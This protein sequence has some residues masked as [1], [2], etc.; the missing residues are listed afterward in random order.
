[1]KTLT[2]ILLFA[3]SICMGQNNKGF[4]S[5]RIGYS[6]SSDTE[7][8]SFFINSIS[9]GQL[10]APAAAFVFTNNSPESSK[11]KREVVYKYDTTVLFNG[12]DTVEHQHI[13]VKHSNIT[14]NQSMSCAAIH[15][16]AGC[17]WWWANDDVICTICLRNVNVR[18]TRSV[19]ITK[20]FDPYQDAKERLLSIRKTEKTKVK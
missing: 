9:S 6:S 20:V 7:I 13:Y 15:D 16:E 11:D 2:I 10:T 17:D 1:M 3:S 18:E 5:T 8:K 4:R 12:M 14:R 19:K